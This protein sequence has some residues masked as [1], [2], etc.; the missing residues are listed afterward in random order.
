MVV[1]TVL[2]VMAYDY[3]PEKLNVYLS[4]D[5]GSDLTFYAI[6][7]AS[8]FSKYWLP[9]CKKFNVEPRSPEAYFRSAV[10]PL[11]E[12]KVKEWLFIKVFQLKSW[13]MTTRDHQTILKILIDGRDPKLVDSE[14]QPLPTLVYLA[15]EKRPQYPH[16]FKA[17]AMNS[18]VETFSFFYKRE[19][20]CGKRYTKEYKVDWKKVDGKTAV[21]CTNALEE[22]SKVLASCSYEEN[23]EWGKEMGL[24]YGYATEDLMTG[25]CIQCRGW[26]SIN[27]IPERKAFWEWLL[28]H[29]C[30]HW[31]N[32]SDGLKAIF[33]SSF[34][35]TALSFMDVERYPSNFNFHTVVTCYGLQ[36]P[37]PLCTTFLCH[38]FACFEESLYSHRH[39]IH[40]S[41]HLHMQFC[42]TVSMALEN[43]FG[44][45][46]HFKVGG[47]TKGCGFS[48]EQLPIFLP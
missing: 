5:G 30:S 13:R 9:F 46:A 3:P 18:L 40:G 19:T 4:D 23:T 36:T 25:L 22:A 27:F 16:H 47:I 45:V 35:N 14:G 41:I 2:S 42:P 8:K 31:S 20:L 38:P 33:I 1:N 21:Y 17:G 48:S 15:R 37:W 39:Q 34:P 28:Q 7:E 11:D 12:P 32:I 26:G 44:V 24:K 6:L 43:L 29:Y 10:E